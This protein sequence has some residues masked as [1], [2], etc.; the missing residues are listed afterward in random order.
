MK[1]VNTEFVLSS[2][3]F[4]VSGSGKTRLSLDGLCQNWGLYISCRPTRGPASGSDDFK[5]ATDMLQ[6][7]STWD[8]GENPEDVLKNAQAA[9]RT[10]TMLLCAR[11]FILK[12]LVQRLPVNTDVMVARRRWV[13]VQA[14]PPSLDFGWPSSDLFVIVLRS[15]RYTSTNIMRQIIRSLLVVITDKR[16]W[17]PEG[18]RTAL[19]VVIDEVQV[20]AD[21]LKEYF[22]STTRTDMRLMKCISSF[23]GIQKSWPGLFSQELGCQ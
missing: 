18:P 16:D 17:F 3:L 7:M 5:V 8:N 19:F 20:A 15:L 22:R 13:L 1:I 14:L 12:Q 4:S 10:F 23:W 2:H 9:D 6:G 11:I 21:N